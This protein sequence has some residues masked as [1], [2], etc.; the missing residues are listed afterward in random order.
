MVL[1]LQ[2]TF[3]FM[4]QN[5]EPTSGSTTSGWVCGPVILE[6]LSVHICR[7]LYI[8]ALLQEVQGN[9]TS[10]NPVNKPCIREYMLHWGMPSLGWETGSDTSRRM[11]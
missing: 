5:N 6:V 3:S 11:D 2:S 4:L 9:G 8:Q 10:C 7:I 1:I